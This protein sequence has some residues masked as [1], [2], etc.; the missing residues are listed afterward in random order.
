M[1]ELELSSECGD[2]LVATIGNLTKEH[3][4]RIVEFEIKLSEEVEY[5]ENLNEQILQG[6]NQECDAVRFISSIYDLS[7]VANYFRCYQ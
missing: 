5:N 1:K 3:S 7:L 6:L 4:A 2:R